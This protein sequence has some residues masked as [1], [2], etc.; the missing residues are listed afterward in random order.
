M[1]TILRLSIWSCLIGHLLF[2]PLPTLAQSQLNVVVGYPPGA[3]Y[4]AYGRLVARH[5]GKHLPGNPT[6]V[7]QNMPGAGSLRAANYHLC[8]CPEGRL[9]HRPVRARHGDAAP[10]RSSRASSSTR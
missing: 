5:I 10:A 2:S 4:D 6:V 3:I 1:P 8:R 7:V 9:D